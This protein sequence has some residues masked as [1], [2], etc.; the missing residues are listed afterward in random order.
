ML[1]LLEGID[2][3]KGEGAVVKHE[4]LGWPIVR[5]PKQ[6]VGA[7]PAVRR[8]RRRHLLC[9]QADEDL[10]R[11]RRAREPIVLEDFGAQLHELVEAEREV[12]HDVLQP[13]VRDNRPRRGATRLESRPMG[14]EGPSHGRVAHL[15]SA[16]QR[17]VVRR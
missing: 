5:R 17:R 9:H 12:A 15:M 7:Q 16:S 13:R 8:E 4:H 11:V 6:K 10:A 3:Q 1:V 14:K 2:T